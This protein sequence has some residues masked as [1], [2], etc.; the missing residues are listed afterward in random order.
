[1]VTGSEF[2]IQGAANK[3]RR[4]VVLVADGGTSIWSCDEDQSDLDGTY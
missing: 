3:K 1:M 2:H 4:S